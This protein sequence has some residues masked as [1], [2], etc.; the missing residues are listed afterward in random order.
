M[1]A[2][3]AH[4][5]NRAYCL[6]LGD[7]SQESWEDAPE[8]QRDSARA[9]VI[10]KLDDPTTTPE[11]S[12]ESWLAQKKA[13]GWTYGVVKD[14]EKKEHPCFV[15]YDQLPLAQKAKDFLFLASVQQG[16]RVYFRGGKRMPSFQLGERVHRK[17]YEESNGIIDAIYIDFQ[18]ARDCG[19]VSADWYECQTIRP[20]S[21]KTDR[22]YSVVLRDGAILAGEHDLERLE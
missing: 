9:G 21:L 14:V 3:L 4:E 7:D 17:D 20:R 8:W 18:A 16:C 13:D 15:P 10:L 12:H 1:C 22:W 11:Q 6:A 2:Q 5:M 19:I